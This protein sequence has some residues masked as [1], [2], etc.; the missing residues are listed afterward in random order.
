[1]GKNKVEN[2]FRSR[3]SVLLPV[4]VFV[5]FSPVIILMIKYMIIP[6]L[7]IMGGLFLLVVILY[8]GIHYIISGDT[9]FFKIW[10]IPTCSLKIK[11]IASIKRSYYLFDIPTNTTA[12]FKKL[13]IEFLRNTNYPYL[14]VSPVREH[15]FIDELKKVNPSIQVCFFDKKGIGR[16]LNCDI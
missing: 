10:F 4:F 9:L 8:S 2:V 15:D 14:H 1:M 12:S 16:I 13:R 7:I 11:N 6:G 3:I 5:L